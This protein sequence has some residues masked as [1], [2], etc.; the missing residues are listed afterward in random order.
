MILMYSQ[1]LGE[2][3]D[4]LVSQEVI[5]LISSLKLKE[6]RKVVESSEEHKEE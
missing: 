5:Q 6:E 2:L 3:D 4:L 1:D